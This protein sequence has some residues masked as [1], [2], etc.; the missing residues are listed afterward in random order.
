MSRLLPAA[1]LIMGAAVTGACAAWD[2]FTW[3]T[4]LV[5]GG[6]VVCGVLGLPRSRRS[7]L[8]E[9]SNRV[10]SGRHRAD[11]TVLAIH[12]HREHQHLSQLSIDYFLQWSVFQIS[13][14][15]VDCLDEADAERRFGQAIASFWDHDAVQLWIWE[16]GRWR[17][18]DGSSDEAIDALLEEVE[19]AVQFGRAE[20]DL[21]IDLSPAVAGRAVLRLLHPRPQPP[22]TNVLAVDERHLIEVLRGQLTLAL[23]RIE[24]YRELRELGRTD[25]LT[26]TWRRWYGLQRLDELITEGRS[27]A[28]AMVDIDYFKMIND[29]WGHRVGDQV[30]S[31]LGTL[32]NRCIRTGDLAC[33][34]GGEEFVLVLPGTSP[35]GAGLVAE[36]LRKTIADLR[37]LP[38]SEDG[39]GRSGIRR[40]G[41]SRSPIA[42]G[43]GEAVTVSIGIA[44]CRRE[45]TIEALIDRADAAMYRAKDG[46]RDRV[47]NDDEESPAGE[48]LGHH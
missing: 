36:R 23:R 40:P 47:V 1:T 45:E 4:S 14:T 28:V 31:D 11:S 7:R 33:R 13:A 9:Q 39:G 29:R 5:I 15:L 3:P 12:R 6:A 41:R 24:L 17:R 22:L 43:D 20:D 27:F 30:L 48:L 35:A 37:A 18:P 2:G 38:V 19:T 25:P 21:I 26:H 16:R 44:A 8:P 34:F 46:G 10:G 32:I 42:N